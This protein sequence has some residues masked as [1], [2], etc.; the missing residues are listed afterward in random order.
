[1][2]ASDSARCNTDDAMGDKSDD[3]GDSDSSQDSY[4]DLIQNGDDRRAQQPLLP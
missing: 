1:M 4:E 3:G 2:T